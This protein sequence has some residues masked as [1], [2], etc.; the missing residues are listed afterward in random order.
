MIYYNHINYC[1][2]NQVKK[3]REM[4]WN[5]VVPR[6]NIQDRKQKIKNGIKKHGDKWHA[7]QKARR[8]KPVWYAL[9]LNVPR[10]C[11]CQ[12]QGRLDIAGLF[13]IPA[14]DQPKGADRYRS[15]P[16]P[17]LRA[18]FMT[19]RRRW[20]DGLGS[21]TIG[22]GTSS[23]VD[24]DANWQRGIRYER[25]NLERATWCLFR[26]VLHEWVTNEPSGVPLLDT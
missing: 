4:R 21:K 8:D 16:P 10:L 22:L 26:I 12:V 1:D 11:V 23:T 25:S 18:S 13:L 3:W 15:C 5:D 9:I 6:L 17:G 24:D 7:A 20:T 14:R 19:E 2:C